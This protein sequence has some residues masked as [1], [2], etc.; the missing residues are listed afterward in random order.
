MK[1]SVGPKP[2]NIQRETRLGYS[3]QVKC[4]NNAQYTL[5]TK[6]L[7][8]PDAHKIDMK[9]LFKSLLLL[10][11]VFYLINGPIFYKVL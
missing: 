11:L 8:E 7:E 3:I 1:P 9:I 10:N 5:F 4:N 6:P 2:Q